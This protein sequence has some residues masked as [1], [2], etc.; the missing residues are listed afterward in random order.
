MSRTHSK[1]AQ[2]GYQFNSVFTAKSIV[3]CE[4]SWRP[5]GWWS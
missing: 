5:T 1:L 3:S 4:T 2:I